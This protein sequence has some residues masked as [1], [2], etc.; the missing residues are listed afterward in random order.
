MQ[1]GYDTT[2][3]NGSNGRTITFPLSTSATYAVV[4][5]P[6]TYVSNATGIS[7]ITS[8]TETSFTIKSNNGVNV[9]GVRYVAVGK[10]QVQWGVGGVV[11]DNTTTIYLPTSF[12]NTTYFVSLEFLQTGIRRWAF[13]RSRSK[14]SFVYYCTGYSENGSSTSVL[15]FACGYQQWGEANGS[16]SSPTTT[17]PISFTS[18]VYRIVNTH[19]RN[20]TIGDTYQMNECIPKNITRQGFTIWVDNGTP[21]KF[22]YISIGYQQWGYLSHSGNTTGQTVPFNISFP[23]SCYSVVASRTDSGA[24]SYWTFVIHTDSVTTTK[25]QCHL[26]NNL[27]WIAIGK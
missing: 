7:A 3:F 24:T 13:L 16:T 8:L 21:A 25:F 20:S 11:W 26:A 5:I 17:F 4:A 19:N 27:Y 22:D 9:T 14:S 23:T 18:T 2:A 6:V 15:W 12:T 10:A 1:W